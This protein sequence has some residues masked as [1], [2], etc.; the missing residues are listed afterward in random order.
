MQLKDGYPANRTGDCELMGLTWLLAKDRSAYMATV[1][2][3]LRTTF[4]AA[5][6]GEPRR[7]VVGEKEKI[8]MAVDSAELGRKEDPGAAASAAAAPLPPPTW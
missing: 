6:G 8:P 4:M 1:T 7:C 3:V 5:A 2:H